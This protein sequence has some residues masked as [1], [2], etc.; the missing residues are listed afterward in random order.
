MCGVDEGLP[1]DAMTATR[2][3]RSSAAS[4]SRPAASSAASSSRPAA[5]SDASPPE[6]AAPSKRRK[7]LSTKVIAGDVEVDVGAP[8]QHKGELME[9]HV[10]ALMDDEELEQDYLLA[11]MQSDVED[12]PEPSGDGAVQTDGACI[13]GHADG[14]EIDVDRVIAEGH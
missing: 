10:A 7:S 8:R 1:R 2:A 13:G 3:P 5:S 9:M 12:A 11:E 14:V 4:S 6:A